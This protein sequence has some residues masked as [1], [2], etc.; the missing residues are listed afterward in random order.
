MVSFV[1]LGQEPVN[2]NFRRQYARAFRGKQLMMSVG[3]RMTWTIAARES[4][5]ERSTKGLCESVVVV[6]GLW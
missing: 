6:K 1:E 2:K 3:Q 4:F 5:S